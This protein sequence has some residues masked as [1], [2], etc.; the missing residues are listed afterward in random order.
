[1]I[2]ILLKMNAHT[3]VSMQIDFSIL[4]QR[5]KSAIKPAKAI[6]DRLT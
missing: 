3:N 5:K 6:D 2:V 1:M 4:S